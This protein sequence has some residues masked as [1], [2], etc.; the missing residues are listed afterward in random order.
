M[1]VADTHSIYWFLTARERLS[2][3]AREALRAA[4]DGDGIAVSAWTV[5]ELWMAATRKRGHRAV[6]PR[7][8]ELVKNTLLDPDTS[9]SRPT[10]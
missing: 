2:S 4:E 6:L 5:P 1:I 8:Y 7:A 9:M 10:I 3:V